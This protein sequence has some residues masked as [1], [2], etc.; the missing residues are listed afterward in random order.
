MILFM[1]RLLAMLLLMMLSDAAFSQTPAS[2][3]KAVRTTLENYLE[4]GTL[5]DSARFAS[6]FESVGEM[7]FMKNDQIQVVPLS[8]FRTNVHPGERQKRK[9]K[10]DSVEIFGNAARAKLTIEYDT[11]YFHD[12]MTLLKTPQGWKIVAKVFYREEKSPQQP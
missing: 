4:G 7:I 8:T 2:E 10:I 5:R 12:L 3:L 1:K 9:T 11:F 6:A